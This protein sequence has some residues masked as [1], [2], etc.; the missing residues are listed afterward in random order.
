MYQE[1]LKLHLIEEVLKVKND[2]ILIELEAVLKKH[3]LEKKLSLSTAQDLLGAWS[4]EDA[5]LIDKA[6]E[7]G[8]E[9]IHPDDW[10]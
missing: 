2:A 8:C 3:E 6:I 1:A 4:K 10:K 7:E 5:A 9:Q